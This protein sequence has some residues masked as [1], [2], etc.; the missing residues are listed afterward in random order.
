MSIAE[1]LALANEDEST[2]LVR[3]DRPLLSLLLISFLILFFELACI[4]WFGSTVTFLTFFT[5]IVL[6]ACFLGM[7]VGCLAAG[8]RQQLVQAAIPL[9]LVSVVL[10]CAIFMAYRTFG[11]LVVDVGGQGSP[12]QVYFGTEERLR[13]PA[14]FVIPIEVIAGTFFVLIALM[15]IGLGQV[16]GR[17]FDA[18][19]NRVM[20]YTTNVLGS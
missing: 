2:G 9:V 12:Q 7:T 18:L 14:D 19:P 13:D 3:R 16:M 1:P 4:R 11:R 20:A 6:I 10:S 5:N 17:A 15:F 8:R